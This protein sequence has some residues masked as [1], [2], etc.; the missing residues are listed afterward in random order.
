[1][2]NQQMAMAGMAGGPVEGTPI[3]A[4]MARPGTNPRDS[5][6][7]YIYDYFLRNNHTRLAQAMLDADLQMN[8]KPPL[9]K[10]SPNGRNVNGVDSMDGDDKTTLPLPILPSNQIVENSFLMD[11]WCQFWDIYSATRSKNAG[12]KS[13]QYAQVARVRVVSRP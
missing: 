6:N 10:P 8:L 3:M 12:G 7:T 13:A 11:W 9:A 4:N 5:I 1:M 2:Q